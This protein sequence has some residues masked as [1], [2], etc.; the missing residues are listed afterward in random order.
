MLSILSINFRQIARSKIIWVLFFGSALI[1]FLGLKISTSLTVMIEAQFQ[2]QL[3]EMLVGSQTVVVILFM[4]IFTGGF[5]ALAYGIWVVPYLHTGG[6]TPLTY[7]L[8]LNKWIYPAAYLSMGALLQLSL[9]GISIIIFGLLEGFGIYLSDFPWLRFSGTILFILV[10][11]SVITLL[12]ANISIY[13]GKLLAFTGITFGWFL[14]QLLEFFAKAAQSQ[15]AEYPTLKVV[16]S[17]LPP[18]GRTFFDI[19]GIYFSQGGVVYSMV[20]WAVWLVVLVS[21]FRWILTQ[22]LRTNK[23]S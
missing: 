4:H 6:R 10:V 8:P 11:M 17:L 9:I 18:L 20:C 23:E 19:Y 15:G 22:P 21:M 13:L 7:C 3:T 14:L 1:Q 2:F 5:L 16:L 12:S